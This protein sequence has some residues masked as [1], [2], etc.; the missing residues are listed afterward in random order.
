MKLTFTQ[1]YKSLLRPFEI[2]NLPDLTILTG[3]NGAGKTHILQAIALDKA[4][5]TDED[6]VE[7]KPKKFINKVSLYPDNREA[8]DQSSGNQSVTRLFQK[9]QDYLSLS[10]SNP[11]HYTKEQA[12]RSDVELIDKILEH[13][14]KNIRELERSDFEIFSPIEEQEVGSNDVFYR[15]FSSIFRKYFLKN[16]ENKFNKFLVQQEGFTDVRFFEDDE[17]KRHFGEPPWD[18]VNKILEEAK[19][20]YRT[21]APGFLNKE[22]SFRLKLVNIHTQVEITL[23]DLS[24]GEAVLMSFGL[25]LYSST[26][27]IEFPKILLLDEPDASLHPSMAKQFLDVIQKVFIK[28][29]G[30][31]VIMT[32]HSPSTV[33]LA[34]EES[35]YVVNKT[36]IRIEK[37]TKDKALRNLTSG[38]PSFSVNYENRRQVFVESRNDV[39]FY[40]RLYDKFR[41]HLDPEISLTFISSGDSRT[42]SNGTPVA[43][44]EQ[45]KKIVKLLRKGGNKFIF[46]IIDWDRNNKPPD[47][48]KIL[49]DGKRYSIEN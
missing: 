25:A 24:S 5:L 43:N 27:E 11:T 22:T 20:D 33:A 18:L 13:T 34:P 9:Y 21:S 48:I 47:S 42:D 4:S 41:S 14:G 37:S 10:E 29:K 31:K 40:E 39:K 30:V 49:G 44:C 3:I 36:D 17:F 23:D 19:S 38:V 7:I 26:H 46:G 15:Q 1:E 2:N 12:L 16:I 32:T 6:G 8:S 45:V 35:I 28:E